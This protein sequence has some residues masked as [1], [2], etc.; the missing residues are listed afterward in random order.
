[1][2]R[3]V[4]ILSGDSRITSSLSC[5]LETAYHQAPMVCDSPETATAALQACQSP[6]TF[7]D[8]RLPWLGEAVNRLRERSGVGG[9]DRASVVPIG[10]RFYPIDVAAELDLLAIAH[11]EN[12]LDGDEATSTL[13][14]LS[15]VRSADGSSRLPPAYSA[16]AAD[17]KIATNT[18]ELVPL[19][20]RLCRMASH[21]VTVLL[22]GET[23]TGKTTL[24]K[25]VHQLS[26]RREHPFHNVACGA[27]PRDL[28]ESELFGH[29]RGAFTG[30]DRTK[31]G[32]FEAAGCGTLLLDEIDVLGPKEQAN[33]LRVI[34]TGEYEMVGSTETRVSQ[35]RLIVASNI[36]LETLVREKRFRSDLYYRLNVLEFHLPPLRERVLDI[37][38][39]AMEF[40]RECCRQHGISIERVHVDFLQALRRYQ[41]PGNIRELKNHIQRA[42]LFCESHD[43]T[44]SDLSPA[45][46]SP[47]SPA[48]DRRPVANGS[49]SLADRVARNE[50]DLIEAALRSN[51][52]KRAATA[53]ALGLSRVGLYK[54][55]KRYGMLD[56]AKEN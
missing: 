46:L 27:L 35:A 1:M 55:M 14:R 39:M 38:P 26:A 2:Q 54:K 32:R 53:K 43:L 21:D 17:V 3:P 34:E 7:L 30:A 4:L 11:L 15:G 51:N 23:G 10:S 56:R 40:V 6:T 45:I 22:V 29:V 47:E 12:P 50:R 36:D 8:L 18:P 31:T 41:W 25:F 24:A 52:Q 48:V 44:T 9:S 13:N 49:W 42:V 20:E 37:V 28:I 16:T 33:L 19:I 5:Y